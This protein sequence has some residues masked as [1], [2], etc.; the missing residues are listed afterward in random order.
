MGQK[1]YKLYDVNTGKIF[2]NRDV[3]F[4]EDTFHHSAPHLEPIPKSSP[5]VSSIPIPVVPDPFSF[6]LPPNTPHTPTHDLPTAPSPPN[7]SPATLSSSP[8]STAPS[9]SPENQSLPISPLPPAGLDDIPAS[10]PI[11]PI[12]PIDVVPNIL[13][14]TN[15][16]LCC[17]EHSREPNVRLKDYV[18]SQVMLLPHSQSSPSP[19]SIPGTRYPLH[20]FLSYHRY[21]PAH[22]AYVANISQ[23][24]E[25]SSYEIAAFDPK[26]QQ[27]MTS[28]LQALIDN[29]TWTLVP[30]PPGKR[31]I[32]STIITG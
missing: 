13:D 10:N 19:S 2:T 9:L 4:M 7:G 27:A 28:E 20:Q 15:P 16:P 29:N 18:C 31:P 23:A 32:D 8:N 17:S 26:W 14:P 1:A 22:L 3:I 6:S 11:E 5:P 24:V 21:S 30:L 12:E 25:P